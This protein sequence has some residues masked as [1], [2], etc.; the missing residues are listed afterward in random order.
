MTSERIPDASGT[1]DRLAPQQKRSRE[2]REKI[3]V[4]AEAVL[5]SAGVD[6]FSM[7]AVAAV[8][9][10]PI[11]NI[12]RRFEGK[13][14]LLLAMKDI[15]SSRIRNGIAERLAVG[16]HDS[17]RGFFTAFAGAVEMAFARDE[18]LNRTLYDP[19]LVNP[20]L[21]KSGQIARTSIFELFDSGL[22]PYLGNLGEQ[23]RPLVTKVAFSIIM[24]AAAFKV[25]DNDPISAG[26]SWPELAGE[27]GDSAFWYVTSKLNVAE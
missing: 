16:K 22:G 9:G 5:R 20:N 25:R 11:G 14:D 13:D 10:M 8:A 21:A 2:A 27:F 15:V 23:T 1:A 24:N 17:L 6:G 18:H 19:R 4:A 12:Y 7:A 26:I 3:I